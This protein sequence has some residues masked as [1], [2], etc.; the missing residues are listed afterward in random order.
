MITVFNKN[1]KAVS[2]IFVH[3][4]EDE[5]FTYPAPLSLCATIEDDAKHLKNQVKFKFASYYDSIL[6]LDF[7]FS[8]FVYLLTHDYRLHTLYI[9]GLEK[10]EISTELYGYGGTYNFS[11]VNVLLNI[12]EEEI[13]DQYRQIS[14]ASV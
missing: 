6:V 4:V 10:E 8:I 2:N 5:K 3:T 1:Y 11:N 9:A 12:G 7:H 13:Y 14:K